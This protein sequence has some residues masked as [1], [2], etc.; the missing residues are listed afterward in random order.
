MIRAFIFDLDGTLVD[1]LDDIAGLMNG[2]L[3]SKAWPEHPTPAYKAMVG[4]GLLNLIRAAVPPAEA[5]NAERL[6]GEVYGMYEGL[7]AG[8]S[9]PYPGAELA[10]A[11]L[12]AAGSGLAVASNKPDAITKAMVKALFPGIRFAYVSGGRDGLP[13]KPDPKIALEAAAA[14][15]AEP[16]EC[17]FV[18]DSDVDMKTAKAAGMLAVGAAWGFRGAAELK[19]AG[20]DVVLGSISEVSELLLGR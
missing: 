11:S 18:G 1:T 10:L 14:C 5:V 19:A 9:R 16:R 20:A 13:S 3:R 2:Y 6:Y 15:G 17:A 7:G 8:S 4:R 12:A